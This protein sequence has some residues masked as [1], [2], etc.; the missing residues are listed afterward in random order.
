MR[1]VMRLLVVAVLVAAGMG[2]WWL[3]LGRPPLVRVTAAVRGPAVEAVYATGTVEPV[4]WAAVAPA[5]KARLR[6]VLADDGDR[7]VAGQV[8]AQLDATVTQAQVAEAE[9]RAQFALQEAERQDRLAV[10]SATARSDVDRARSEAHALEAA[11]E[12]VRR[13]LDDFDLKAPIDGWSCAGTASPGRWSIP[14]TPCSGSGRASR[15]ASPP[16]STRRTCRACG[17]GRGPC[18]G[19]TPI[20][21]ACSRAGWWRSRPR[22]TRCRKT[23]RVRIE[24]PDDAPLMIGMT[25]EANI[26]V[27]ETQDAVLVPT[28]AVRDG[29]VYVVTA[30]RCHRR[31]VETGV[32][33]PQ[34]TEIRSGLTVGETVVVE[35]PAG[36][37]SGDRVRI[38]PGG[39]ADPVRRRLNRCRARY[40]WTSLGPSAQAQAAD[41]GLDPGRGAGRRVLHRHQRADARLPAVFRQPDH[42]R[43]TAHRHQGRIPLG[44]A[45]AGIRGLP[46]RSGHRQRGE[47]Q[48]RAARHPQCPRQAR[49]YRG[50]SGLGGSTHA[51]GP[52]DP[53]LRTRDVP[54]SLY[55]ID[56]SASGA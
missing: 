42:R 24:L 54:V 11:A 40:S 33:G 8:L 30:E 38:E 3:W 37:A 1:L 17:P 19:P 22:A 4:R 13:R 25:V 21:T 26:V 27:R 32:A 41:H 36:L 31:A 2:V 48:G 44:L 28:T 43:G 35:P 10:R 18:C 39:S 29:G 23:Y 34:L 9:A 7:V 46:D 14:P 55:G 53:T 16:T 20:P 45:A 49:R 56:P 12:A 51:A 52:G 15:C 47:A 50:H 6:E 5:Q